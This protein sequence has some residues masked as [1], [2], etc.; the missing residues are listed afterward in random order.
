[1]LSNWSRDE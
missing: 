1:L